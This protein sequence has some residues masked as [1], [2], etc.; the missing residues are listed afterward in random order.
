MAGASLNVRIRRIEVYQSTGGTS[1]V[2]DFLIYRLSSAGTGGTV[3]TPS[4]LDPSD[5]G[6]G[7][8]VMTLPSAKGT[9][10]VLIHS[11]SSNTSSTSTIPM[12]KMFE[13]DFDRE[14]RMKGLIIPAGASNGIA[15]KSITSST[16]NVFVDVWFT[17][18][19][20]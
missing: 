20:F 16:A 5:A 8:T 11:T 15:I 4:P 13:I 7:A 2:G 3:L 12:G 14:L 1:V 9:E 18:T 17:E 19:A 6:S 10:G